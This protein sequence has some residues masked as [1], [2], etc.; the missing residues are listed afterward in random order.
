MKIPGLLGALLLAASALG[1]C[2]SGSTAT[3]GRTPDSTGGSRCLSRPDTSGT[4]PLF[5]LFCIQSG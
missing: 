2:A 3:T 1:G 5:Y 4:Q